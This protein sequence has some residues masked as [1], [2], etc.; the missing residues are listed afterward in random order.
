[1]AA[2]CTRAVNEHLQSVT[3][4]TPPNTLYTREELRYMSASKLLSMSAGVAGVRG[5]LL[6]TEVELTEEEMNELEEVEKTLARVG[7]AVQ[8]RMK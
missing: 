3:G 8:L 5:M 6:A 1:M 7:R 2:Q 4:A